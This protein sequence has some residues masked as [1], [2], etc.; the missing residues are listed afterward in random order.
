MLP[1]CRDDKFC[2]DVIAQISK[3]L[4]PLEASLRDSVE[5]MNGSEQ[6]RAALDKAYAAQSDISQK[7]TAL[8]EQMV[9]SGYKAQVPPEYDDLPQLE[10]RATVEFLFKK[11]GGAPFNVNGQNFPQAKLTMIIDGYT[12]KWCML[13]LVDKAIGLLYIIT[14]RQMRLHSPHHYYNSH[15][16]VYKSSSNRRQ[17][18]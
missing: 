1:S 3:K 17:L 18:Y 15:S 9:P 12:G 16:C 13:Q 2:A 4:D 11:D 8:Q 14:R 6:E 7:I 5:Y 10:G